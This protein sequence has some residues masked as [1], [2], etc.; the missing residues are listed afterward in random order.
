[1]HSLLEETCQSISKTTQSAIATAGDKSVQKALIHLKR[2]KK[3]STTCR[4]TFLCRNQ[5]IRC[6]QDESQQ[7]EGPAGH[8]HRFRV[9]CS[10]F[11]SSA[12]N[13]K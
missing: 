11:C 2:K 10:D 1:M 4:L 7:D 8:L 9:V 6:Q 5:E 12:V 13:V 3:K